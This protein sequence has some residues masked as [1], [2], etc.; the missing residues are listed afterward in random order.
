MELS[1]GK[2][3]D[4]NLSKAVSEKLGSETEKRFQMGLI[5]S[6][7]ERYRIFST[8]LTSYGVLN[9]LVH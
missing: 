9:F 2:I 1:D 8:H 7:F 3:M 6:R 5:L 4:V